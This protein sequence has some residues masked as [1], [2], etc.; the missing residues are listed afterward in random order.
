[1]HDRAWI[2]GVHNSIR[3]TLAEIDV[4]VRKVKDEHGLNIVFGTQGQ[5]GILRT[6]F[7]SVAI[8]WKQP[9]LN[10]VGDH[11]RDECYLRVAEYSGMLPLPGEGMWYP[12]QPRVLREWKFKV[13]VAHDR[14]LV[15]RLAGKNEQ[16]IPASQLADRIVQIFLD[17]MSRAN[18]GKVDPPHL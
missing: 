3:Q 12:E 13:D 9:I 10:Y 5:M 14:S 2:G 17:F 8:A 7:V 18:Q 4:L 15:W 16:M 11:Y 6:G 1:M